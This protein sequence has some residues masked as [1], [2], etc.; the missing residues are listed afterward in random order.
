MPWALLDAAAVAAMQ[1]SCLPHLPV[2]FQIPGGRVASALFMVDTGAGGVDL[3]FHARAA[4]ELGLPTSGDGVRVSAGVL[5]FRVREKGYKNW[6]FV[7]RL[8]TLSRTPMLA[9]C[10]LDRSRYR[11]TVCCQNNKVMMRA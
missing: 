9:A 4:L 5:W 2:T 8:E 3:L 6:T 7:F 1:I 10:Y 11:W